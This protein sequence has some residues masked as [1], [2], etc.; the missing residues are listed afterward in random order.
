[1]LQLF[2]LEFACDV[3]SEA[4][5]LEPVISLGHFSSFFVRHYDLMLGLFAFHKFC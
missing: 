1:M 2:S 4:K 3:L 5:T